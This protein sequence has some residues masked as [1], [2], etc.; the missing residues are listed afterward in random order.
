MNEDQFNIIKNMQARS[1][2]PDKVAKSFHL[3]LAQVRKIYG[4]ATWKEYATELG[5]AQT[6]MDRI[7]GA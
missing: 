3:P 1:V 6:L 2:R 7:F 5:E 4:S